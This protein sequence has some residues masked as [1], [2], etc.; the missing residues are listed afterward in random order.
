MTN[1]EIYVRIKSIRYL[2]DKYWK[3]WHFIYRISCGLKYCLI[4]IHVDYGV[5]RDCWCKYSPLAI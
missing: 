1:I 5:G 3:S 4:R 2:G